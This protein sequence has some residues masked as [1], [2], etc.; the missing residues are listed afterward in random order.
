MRKGPFKAYFKTFDGYSGIE[1]QPHDPPLL[2]Q[3]DH[4]PSE[5]FNVADR[6]PEVVA[7]IRAIFKKH[8]AEIVPGEPQMRRA[9]LR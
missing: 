9:T 7:E 3:L 2:F 8:V 4:D 5:K 6:H 1:P